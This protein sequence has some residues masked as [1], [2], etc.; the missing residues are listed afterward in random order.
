MIFHPLF[1]CIVLRSFHTPS[2]YDFRSNL[3]H[4]YRYKANAVAWVMGQRVNLLL[5]MSEIECKLKAMLNLC[6]V[7]QGES[8][9]PKHSPS[10]RKSLLMRT[11][12]FSKIK[13]NLG[14][15]MWA[16]ILWPESC[17]NYK[18]QL[19]NLMYPGSSCTGTRPVL[20]PLSQ[21]VDFLVTYVEYKLKAMGIY[22]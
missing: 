18:T 8:D 10:S 9:W 12:I 22:V 21:R 14:C 19:K 4:S 20:L 3:I 17:S 11:A 5:Q 7:N 1:C 6:A 13:S 16:P 15:Q 2:R